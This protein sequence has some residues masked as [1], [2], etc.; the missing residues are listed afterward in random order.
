VTI[1]EFMRLWSGVAYIPWKNFFSL[2]GV[3]PQTT[4]SDSIVALK[5]LLQDIGYRNIEIS[6]IWDDLTR[7]A[8]MD[9][10]ARHGIKVDGIVGPLTKIVL[11]NERRNL[12]IPHL[13]N[14]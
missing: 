1:R 14:D 2:A 3:I 4:S 9:V 12:N 8:V 6:P 10:Q 11:Y 5:M 7:N 13:I